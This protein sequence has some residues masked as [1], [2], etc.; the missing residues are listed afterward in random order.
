MAEKKYILKLTGEE[1]QELTRITRKGK[2]AVWKMKRAEALLKSD[3][4][5]QGPA[6]TDARIA[7]AYGVTTRSIESW[8][9]QAVEEVPLSLLERKPRLTPPFDL[10]SSHDKFKDIFNTFF[11][12]QVEHPESPFF[13]INHLNRSF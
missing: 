12:T 1:R 13:K 8:R 4:G 3:Q 10:K 7:E 2:S 5:P 11:I 6:W 9:K